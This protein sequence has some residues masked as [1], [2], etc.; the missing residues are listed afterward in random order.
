V[1]ARGLVRLGDPDS[2]PAVIWEGAAGDGRLGD[3]IAATGR[4]VIMTDID[5]QRRGIG[6]HDFHDPPPPATAGTIAVTNLPWSEERLDPFIAL[7][8]LDEM[9]GPDGVTGAPIR[10]R[11]ENA[12]GRRRD[13]DQFVEPEPTRAFAAAGLLADPQP[14]IYSAIGPARA[15]EGLR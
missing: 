14:R 7:S 2:A 8:M 12:L 5:P 1:P 13:A 9:F 15:L 4:E 11:R 3:D 10:R 6:R